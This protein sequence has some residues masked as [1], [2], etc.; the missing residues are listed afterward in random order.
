MI[1]RQDIQGLRAIAVLLVWL[2]HISDK[3]LPGGFI[4]VDVFFVISGFLIGG[5]ILTQKN[6]GVFSFK[7]FY[8]SRLKRI[9]PAYYVFLLFICIGVAFLYLPVIVIMLQK[10][11]IYAALFNSNNYFPLLDNYFGASLSQ[12]PL[13]HTWTLA[14]EMQF[15]FILP[16][17]L[18]FFNKKQSLGIC[19]FGG[20]ALLVYTQYELVYNQNQKFM[21]FS[22]LARAPEFLLGVGL[23]FL[24]IERINKRNQNIMACLGI[25]FIIISSIFFNSKTL[26]PGLLSLIPCLGA[27]LILMSPLSFFNKILSTRFLVYLGGISYSLYLW[28]WGVLA[29]FRYRFDTYELTMTQ[30]VW[31]VVLTLIL[32]VLSFR[33]IEQI[34]KSFSLKKLSVLLIALCSLLLFVIGGMK[35]Y[36]LK[37]YVSFPLDYTSAVCFDLRTHDQYVKDVIIGDT[38]ASDTVLL[39]GNSHALVM[40]PFLGKVGERYGY[41]L[42]TIT[43]N[44]YIPLDG[45]GRDSFDDDSSYNKYINLCNITNEKLSSSRLIIIVMAYD[46]VLNKH[47]LKAF[48][49]LSSKLNEDQQVI[50]LSDFPTVGRN[51][52]VINRGIVRNPMINHDFIKSY[53]K[54]PT[55]VLNF[56]A[57]NFHFHYFDLSSS[58][59]FD[60]AP[61]YQDTIMYYDSGH[62]NVYGSLVYEKYSGDKVGYFIDSLLQQ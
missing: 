43:L 60:N 7:S 9:V 48:E 1:F 31:A 18:M 58:E 10:N 32:S 38:I 36:A 35:K 16:L 40:K 19:V 59:A 22:L 11:F 14:I 34:I 62:L 6:K 33:F 29:L 12:N 53:S 4:G 46:N 21:Y 23:N 30:Y 28:H 47:L 39:I 51:P 3:I 50:L 52:I 13:L 41:A 8:V 45:Y 37:E 26:Y 55:E 20:I 44:R 57:S 2:F 61:Y 24:P 17:I 54:P 15:Y 56:I 49:M 42:R 25:A 27:F 5:I